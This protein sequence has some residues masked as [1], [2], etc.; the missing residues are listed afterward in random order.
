MKRIAAGAIFALI[1]A[2]YV[3][4]MAT[5][6]GD[7]ALPLSQG[8]SVFIS[9]DRFRFESVSA[10]GSADG[11]RPGDVLDTRLLNVAQR[12]AVWNNAASAHSTIS[13]PVERNGTVVNV[14]QTFARLSAEQSL[15]NGVYF[16]IAC[17]SLICGLVLMLRGQ[18]AS[19]FAAGT[20]LVSLGFMTPS[21]PAWNGPTWLIVSLFILRIWSVTLFAISASVLGMLLWNERTPRLPRVL[22]IATCTLAIGATF[23]YWTVDYTLWNFTGHTIFR[24]QQTFEYSRLAEIVAIIGVFG[25]AALSARGADSPAI[26]VLFASTLIGLSGEAYHLIWELSAFR[27]AGSPVT[28]VPYA[29]AW[30]VLFAGYLYA[31]FSRRLVSVDF[32]IN[33]AAVFS[34]VS[35][36]LIGTFVL[37]EWI[38]TEWL[39]ES[40]HTTN[41]MAGAGVALV[42]G[43]SVR[44]VHARVERVVDR[45]FFRKRYEDEKAIRLL[46]SEAPYITDPEV[47]LKRTATT[48]ERHAGASF[49]RV[50]LDDGNGF[51]GAI[52]ENDPAIVRLRATRGVL[53]LHT[54]DSEL[55]GELAYP[56]V[57]RGRLIGV[58]TVGQRRSGEAY[59]SDESAA[60]AEAAHS[61]GAALDVL[62][63]KN[64]ASIDVMLEAIR[65]LPDTI[66]DRLRNAAL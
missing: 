7:A 64:A 22:L 25:L 33:R 40:S 52:S 48:L 13:Y 1:A 57:A 63:A 58:L 6:I 38:L 5:S 10:A 21:Y 53:D 43:L 29:A 20:M 66:A 3:G 36:V 41:A 50:V 54:V 32:I 65:A 11:V 47:L 34:G 8:R 28:A 26:R 55:T 27:S 35:I 62:S 24:G 16:A 39:R 23:T 59:A 12:M 17:A 2:I 46:A 18:G 4:T 37:F 14:R 42:L 56:M 15:L 49:A 31:F 60:I 19:S 45:V 30:C 44:F 51:Y 9:T 61:I